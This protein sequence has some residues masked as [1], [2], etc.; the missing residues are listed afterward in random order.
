MMLNMVS[1]LKSRK[2]DRLEVS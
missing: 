2:V 1:L